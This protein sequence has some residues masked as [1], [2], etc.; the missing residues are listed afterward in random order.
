[1]T[2]IFRNLIFISIWRDSFHW[3]WSTQPIVSSIIASSSFTFQLMY[4][5]ASI[6]YNNFAPI[7]LVLQF[8]DYFSLPTLSSFLLFALEVIFPSFPSLISLIHKIQPSGLSLK[9][10]DHF[11]N[12]LT[13]THQWYLSAFRSTR[14]N[15]FSPHKVDFFLNLKT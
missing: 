13:L 3:L 9:A 15:N 5:F 2:S 11:L 8:A 4:L 7:F 12:F 1:M 14:T 6:N 10:Q